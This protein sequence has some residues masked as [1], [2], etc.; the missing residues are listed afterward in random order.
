MHVMA[1]VRQL[2][3]IRSLCVGVS[4]Y[5]HILLSLMNHYF[6]GSDTKMSCERSAAVVNGTWTNI[7]PLPSPGAYYTAMVTLNGKAYMKNSHGLDTNVLMHDGAT[8][9]TWISKAVIPSEQREHSLLELDN[10]RALLC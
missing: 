4:D 9:G 2:W 6:I 10:D 8:P 7:A 3:E 1:L 5:E